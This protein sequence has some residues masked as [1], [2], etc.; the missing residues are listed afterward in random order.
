M[1]GSARAKD[2]RSYEFHCG[3]VA[4]ELCAATAA[5]WGV[6]VG[7]ERKDEGNGLRGFL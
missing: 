4:V 2:E 5:F 7:K 6:A 1:A 3:Q